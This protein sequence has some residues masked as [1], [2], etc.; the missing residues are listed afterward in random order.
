VE[1]VIALA[2]VGVLGAGITTFTVQTITESNRSSFHTQAIQ[3]LENAGYWV[4]RDVQMA[5]TVAPGPTAG[6]PLSANWTDENQNTFQVT[7]SI[8][9]TQLQRSLV[10]NSGAPQNMLLVQSINSSPTLT[11]CNY[12]NSLLTFNATSQIKNWSVSR[13][14]QIKKRPS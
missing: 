13:T 11:S 4:S 9:G 12:T 2:L 5:Q 7:L 3:Q 6:F 8:N 1:F 10:K 14:F